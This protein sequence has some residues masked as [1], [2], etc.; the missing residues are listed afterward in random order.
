[1]SVT[2]PQFNIIRE[3]PEVNILCS[4]NSNN[5]WQSPS[6]NQKRLING[7]L[8][9]YPRPREDSVK[10][11][12]YINEHYLP[13]LNRRYYVE[14]ES[15][16]IIV[17]PQDIFPIGLILELQSEKDFISGLQPKIICVSGF[18]YSENIISQV[19]SEPL[20][21]KELMKGFSDK[22]LITSTHNRDIYPL[23]G[24][25]RKSSRK[26]S[27]KRKSRMKKS[28]K[29]KSRMKKS[30]KKKSGKKKSNLKG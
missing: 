13:Y 23:S 8:K 16:K 26:K 19:T 14:Y 12:E 10:N 15:L 21:D 11:S 20:K 28:N 18:K 4:N 29:K 30:N 24:G 6:R 9:I 7:F 5:D 22:K 17:E 2:S 3:Y 1:M 27:K 25:S